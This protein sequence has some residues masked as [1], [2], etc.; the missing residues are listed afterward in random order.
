MGSSFQAPLP[1]PGRKSRR[2]KG[3]RQRAPCPFPLLLLSFRSAAPR[4]PTHTYDTSLPTSGVIGL[5]WVEKGPIAG[6]ES[7]SSSRERGSSLF[8]QRGLDHPPTGR[9]T[10]FPGLKKRKKKER[11]ELDSL[12]LTLHLQR[13]RSRRKRR[14]GSGP[15]HPRYCPQCSALAAEAVVGPGVLPQGPDGGERRT[16]RCRRERRRAGPQ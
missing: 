2:G 12:S 11:E 4:L 6:P 13:G 1:H 15:S 7:E 10:S 8:S 14:V 5:A 3:S 16:A 9:K